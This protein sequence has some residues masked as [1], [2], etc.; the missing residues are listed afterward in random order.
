M[1]QRVLEELARQRL[2]EVREQAPGSHGSRRATDSRQPLEV[3][4]IP[5]QPLRVRA[6][7]TLVD[8]GL[9][10]AAQPRAVRPRPA[11]S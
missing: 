3:P 7:W 11:G 6:G 5:Q 8:L 10:L 9:R 2:A 4:R 1:N